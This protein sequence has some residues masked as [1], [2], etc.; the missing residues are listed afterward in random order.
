[1]IPNQ[2]R[3]ARVAYLSLVAVLPLHTVYF[4]GVIALK[5]WLVLVVVVAA[6]DLWDCRKFPWH[7]RSA[8]ALGIFL[9]C[10]FASWPSIGVSEAFW[11]LLAALA[12]GALLMMVTGRHA[13]DLDSVLKVVFWSAAAMA[14]TGFALAMMTNGVFGE[15]AVNA[16]NDIPGVDRIN[17]PAYMV[18]LLALTN[19]HQ[20]PGYSALWTN[21]WLVLAAFA[22]IRGVV[23]GPVWLGPVV[24]G[25][26]VAA[27]I[28]TYSRTG[29]LGLVIALS[30]VLF[31]HRKGRRD[32]AVRNLG[33][34]LMVAAVLLGVLILT[35][36]DGVGGEVVDSLR[37]RLTHLVDLGPIEPGDHVE[38][39]PSLGEGDNR[40][41]V[42][43]E[44][45]GRF[46]DSPIRGIGLG[47]G[48][49]ETDLQEPHNLWLQLLGETGI[50][51]ML[52][53][54]AL[55]ASQRRRGGPVAGSALTIVGVASVTQTVIFE[56][57][58]WFALGLWLAHTLNNETQ[59]P[60][61]AAP[62]AS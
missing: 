57:A 42:W 59:K 28:M 3:V 38:I 9:A 32:L 53:F 14:A 47:T 61:I 51:G 50:I 31:H 12:V 41:E 54:L 44:Y 56:P 16:I 1:M 43:A 8:S 7:R 36:R 20:D 19:W 40:A 37:F 5:A 24:L 48:W 52:G 10:A 55:L 23:R 46:L 62:Q 29:W 17:K 26:L 34:A 27:T 39:D 2:S 4:R 58:L 22:W 45:W 30:V 33:A 60:L 21:V 25:G 35:D 18:G 49:S 6:A 13:R 11:R 15:E